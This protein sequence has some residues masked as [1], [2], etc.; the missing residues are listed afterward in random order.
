MPVELV[1]AHERVIYV[2]A[3]LTTFQVDDPVFQEYICHEN[4]PVLMLEPVSKY[5][6]VSAKLPIGRSDP[7]ATELDDITG[8]VMSVGGFFQKVT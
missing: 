5:P 1:A 7:L 3:R 4:D 6:I 2:G 8:G